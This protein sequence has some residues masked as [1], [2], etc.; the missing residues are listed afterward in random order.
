LASALGL[1]GYKQM[2]ADLFGNARGLNG[3]CRHNSKNCF[4]IVYRPVSK[5][6]AKHM[7]AAVGAVALAGL[8]G[9]K[10]L[11][12]TPIEAAASSPKP[13]TPDAH[14][15][16]EDLNARYLKT[17]EEG[18][19]ETLTKQNFPDF[20]E[21]M[22]SQF[23]ANKLYATTVSKVISAYNLGDAL[24]YAIMR[25]TLKQEVKTMYAR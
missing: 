6:G 11:R 17:I 8:A 22:T 2:K 12:Q 18:K 23:L 24:V 20:N 16:M 14:K 25:S 3:V 7:A 10:Y 13:N 19:D 15:R 21:F 9:S 4:A 5:F 1:D